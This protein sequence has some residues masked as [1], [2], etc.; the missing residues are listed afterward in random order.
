MSSY[1]CKLPLFLVFWYRQNKSI[2]LAKM[3]IPCAHENVG[4]IRSFLQIWLHSVE[5]KLSFKNLM[6][7]LALLVAKITMLQF[8]FCRGY[9][10]SKP[11]KL[12]LNQSYELPLF[13]W[14][15]NWVQSNVSGVLVCHRP[16]DRERLYWRE[17][18]WRVDPVWMGSSHGILPSPASSPLLI[19]HCHCSPEFHPP[20]FL[21]WLLHES[22]LALFQFS[23]WIYTPRP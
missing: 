14:N 21:S 3:L 11:E 2:W 16:G 12:Q 13:I 19:G 8:A 4:G 20:A 17:A 7:C 1:K 10:V 15:G 9:L 18:V 6:K 22:W 23:T 5:T